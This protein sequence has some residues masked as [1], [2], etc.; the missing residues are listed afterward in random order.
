MYVCVRAGGGVDGGRG[1]G[2]HVA[3]DGRAAAGAPVAG[4][5]RARARAA[6]PHVRRGAARQARHRGPHRR[7]QVHAH[8]RTLQVT[9]TI[10]H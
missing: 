8:A 3:G 10:F 5:R 1:A 6:R 9:T 7:R 4:L 2:R